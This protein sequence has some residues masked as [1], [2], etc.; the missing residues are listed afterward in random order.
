MADI[1]QRRK[2]V[3][4]KLSKEV[5]AALRACLFKHGISMQDVFDEFARQLVEGGR[6]AN[7]VLES[8]VSRKL[9]EQISGKI[10]PRRNEKFGEL[11]AEA[12]YSLIDTQ[13]KSTDTN[14]TSLEKIE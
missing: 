8:L 10:R 11:D 7:V 12:L 9:K 6:S 2:C 4:L 13:E 5:H 3:H 1:F 14:E